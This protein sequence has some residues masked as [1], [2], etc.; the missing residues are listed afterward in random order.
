MSLN[1][2]QQ[3]LFNDFWLVC[4]AAD[5]VGSELFDVNLVTEKLPDVINLVVDHG[6]PL[7]GE[8]PSQDTAVLGQTHWLK[9]FWPENSR[10]SDF[11]HLFKLRVVAEDL[12]GGLGVWVVSRLEFDLGDTDL[13]EELSNDP[14]KV[15]EAKVESA[16][17]TLNLVEFSKVSGIESFISE[18]PVNRE[19]FLRLEAILSKLVEHTGRD[20]SGMC[21]ENISLSL[22]E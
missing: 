16:D 5:R 4:E 3:T 12:H 15:L 10:I 14:H 17:N 6:W 20:S 7:K 19:H 1:G 13:P 18:Y 2:T 21:P 11:D 9:H 8:S 22:I